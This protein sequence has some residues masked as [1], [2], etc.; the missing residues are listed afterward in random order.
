MYLGLRAVITKS[1]ARIHHA[2]L[3]NFGIPPLTFADPADFD[4]IEQ[5]DEIVID[6]VL[7]ALDTGSD[8][9]AHNKTKGFE[10]KLTHSW[11]PFNM[12]VL[13]AGGL[14]NYTRENAG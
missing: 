7:A 9:V 14:L 10:F 5:D 2:N 8:L 11:T 13:R 3:V 6:G 4:R 12:K 1:F